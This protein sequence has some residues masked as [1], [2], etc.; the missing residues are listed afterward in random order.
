MYYKVRRHV[1]QFRFFSFLRCP[2]VVTPDGVYSKNI[3]TYIILIVVAVNCLF[4]NVI[5][6]PLKHCNL[7]ANLQLLTSVKPYTI[8]YG[9]T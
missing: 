7:I 4:P 2:R 8:D 3:I 1:R 6:K 9:G 5:T